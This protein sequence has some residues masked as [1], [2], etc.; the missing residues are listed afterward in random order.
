M[1][2]SGRSLHDLSLS[3]FQSL[4]DNHIPEGPHLEYK[5][6]AY[7]GKASDIREMLRD[8]TALANADG[9]YLVMGIREDHAGRAAA[10]SLIDDPRNRVQAIN[11]ACLDGIQERIPGL[12]VVPYEAGFNQGIIV[13][14]VPPSEQRPH[15]MARDHNTDFICRYGADKREMT[16]GEIREMILGN[17]RYR[18]LVELEILGQG[19][20]PSITGTSEAEGP[21]FAQILTERT[22]EHFLRRYLVGSTPPQVMVIVSPFIS[23]L[24]GEM[25]EL[26]DV[27]KRINAD[28]T[29][30]YVVTQP[31]RET[32][33]H[34]GMELLKMSPFVEIRY[35]PDV[36]AKLYICWHR[37]EEE[38]FALFGSGNL[39]SG[40]VRY[41]LELGMMILARGYGK[42]LIRELYDWSASALRTKSERVKAIQAPQ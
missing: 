38:N 2:F 31:P 5:E 1:I 21:P 27:L 35:N 15:M 39:T 41:N 30:T 17:S 19:Q 3:D 26:R 24:A 4:I 7:S 8:V 12:E 18:R 20:R 36:H 22:V 13:V 10:L 33:Q 32:Y 28:H 6:S 42:K 11:Q 25:Y 14:R 40:G 23:D 34:A 9:G 37:E 16:L 29:R